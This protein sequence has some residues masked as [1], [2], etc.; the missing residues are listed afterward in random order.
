MSK[1]R[2]TL[3]QGPTQSERTRHQSRDVVI[4]ASDDIGLNMGSCGAPYSISSPLKSDAVAQSWCYHCCDGP[5]SCPSF[6]GQLHMD[7]VVV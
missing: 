3:D 4:G 1:Q 7:A 2:P 5:R 6:V